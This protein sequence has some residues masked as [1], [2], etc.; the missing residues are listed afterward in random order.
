MPLCI[1]C[2]SHVFVM[3]SLCIVKASSIKLKPIKIDKLKKQE[4]LSG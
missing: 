1:S 4:V 2:I 3:Y